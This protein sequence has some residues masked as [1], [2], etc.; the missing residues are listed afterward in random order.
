MAS[1]TVK[2]GSAVGLHVRPAAI[3]ADKAAEFAEEITM[4]TAGGAP[5]LR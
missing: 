2:V 5:V 3:I 1:K 4:A